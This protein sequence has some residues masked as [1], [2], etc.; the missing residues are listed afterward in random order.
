MAGDGRL[1]TC[2]W[3]GGL[4]AVCRSCDR[5]Q[6]YCSR[7]HAREGRRRSLAEAGRRY[8]RTPS[9]KRNNRL[10]QA[11]YR[12]RRALGEPL[13]SRQY[14]KKVTHQGSLSEA[15]RARVETCETP[16]LCHRYDPGV[17]RCAMCDGRI[18]G[19]RL[20][21][22]FCRRHSSWYKEHGHDRP[23]GR[24]RDHAAVRRGKVATGDDSSSS[25]DPP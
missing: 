7:A 18:A 12:A 1:V 15:D 16:A 2:A 10:R 22:D 9:G 4:F 21:S 5:G 6:Q 17:L 20:R 25:R 23:G 11:R 19:N 8:Q 14:E 13:I 3:C 24:C